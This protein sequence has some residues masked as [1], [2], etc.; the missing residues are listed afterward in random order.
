MIRS[1]VSPDQHGSAGAYAILPMSEEFRQLHPDVRVM[2]MQLQ[3]GAMPQTSL[4]LDDAWQELH[5][6]WRGVGKA[7]IATDP[8]IRPYREFYRRIG[9]NP[10][11]SPPSTQGLIQRYLAGDKLRPLPPLPFIVNLI[12]IVAVRCLVPLGAFDQGRLV[13]TVRVDIAPPDTRMVP[14][15]GD[16]EIDIPSGAVVLRDDEKVLS[17]FCYRDADTQKITTESRSI[18]VLA[19]QVSGIDDADIIASLDAAAEALRLHCGAVT[20]VAPESC[21]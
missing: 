8:K 21:S 10:D 14:I 13:G 4:A 12:N 6:K 17:Q 3:C 5:G 2:S 19:C 20:P 16:S 9:L 18:R 11:R 1:D 15:G 7:A